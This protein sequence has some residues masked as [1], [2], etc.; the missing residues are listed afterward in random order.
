MRRIVLTAVPLLLLAVGCAEDSGGSDEPTSAAPTN[1]AAQ[2]TAEVEHTYGTSTVDCGAERV[3]TLGWG[4]TEAALSVGVVPVAVPH[5]EDNGGIDGGLHPWVAEHL[6][7][8]G[9]DEPELL[10]VSAGGEPPLEEIATLA[11]DLI[12]ATEA[13]ITEDQYELLTQIAPT[14]VHPGKPW[15]TPWRD[16]VTI[17]GEALCRSAEAEQVLTDLDALTAEV[18]A[19]HPEFAGVSI[20]AAESY[21]GELLVYTRPEPRAELLADLG[22]EVDSYG[23]T[24]GYHELSFEQLGEI[25]SDVLLMYHP[26]EGA[27]TEFEDGPGAGLLDQLETGRVASVVGTANVA[28][29]SPPT[30]LSW[31]WTIEA[32]ADELGGAIAGD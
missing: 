7:E 6:E 31:P 12:L 9:W 15:A 21:D 2:E 5:G 14:V 28:A 3:V 32:F 17:S 11:P 13:G 30:A 22:F 25:E 16:V 29:V 8:Q 1:E 18:A 23:S 4:A 10:S 26:S 20:T 24:S 27:R 19:D